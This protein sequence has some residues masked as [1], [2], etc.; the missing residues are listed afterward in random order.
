MSTDAQLSRQQ[1]HITVA[2]PDSS[3]VTLLATASGF[4]KQQIKQLM[5]SG[6]V[7]LTQGK[8]TKRLR[9]AKKNLPTGSELHL[10]FDQKIQQAEIA[11]PHLLADEGDYSVWIKLLRLANMIYS[12]AASRQ[13]KHRK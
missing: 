4:S 2:H 3:A 12:S 10:Y 5:H 6:A 8:Q 13:Y 1:F 7:W 11:E 9:R